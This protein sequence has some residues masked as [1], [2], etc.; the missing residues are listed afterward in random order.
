[1]QIT[2]PFYDKRIVFIDWLI[3]YYIDIT[4]RDA[5]YQTQVIK[6]CIIYIYNLI[7]AIIIFYIFR[8]WMVSQR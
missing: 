1:M 6:S 3:Y 5:S 7:F 2:A 4:Q 8:G